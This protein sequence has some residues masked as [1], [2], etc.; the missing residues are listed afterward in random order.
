MIIKSRPPSNRLYD[1]FL[2]SLDSVLFPV[3]LPP[4]HIL[5]H[6]LSLDSHAVGTSCFSVVFSFWGLW[7]WMVLLIA[8]SNPRSP[9]PTTPRLTPF[10]PWLAAHRATLS[11][12]LSAAQS[13]HFP[14]S[15]KTL[16]FYLFPGCGS[17]DLP[18]NPQ[19]GT[20]HSSACILASPGNYTGD[21]FPSSI[22][23]RGICSWIGPEFGGG[24]SG[25]ECWAFL[26][27]LI[28]SNQGFM[29]PSPPYPR[30]RTDLP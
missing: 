14:K 19:G 12:S 23:L 25:G 9:P 7:V 30:V 2:V 10:C 28:I 26:S 29:S 17:A 11:C 6:M 5:W 8:I 15:H 20:H 3:S 24:G 13:Q 22:L 16:H 4:W 1:C 21:L 18:P 27:T